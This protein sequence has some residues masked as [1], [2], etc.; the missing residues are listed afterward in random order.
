[1]SRK[2]KHFVWVEIDLAALRHNLRGLRALARKSGADMLAI[3]KADAYG[4]G[5]SEIAKALS[6]EGVKFFGVATLD[7]AEKL[8]VQLPKSKI[9]VLGSFHTGQVARYVKAGVRPTISSVEDLRNFEKGF[10]KAKYPVHVKVD[11]GMG[12]LGVWH[13]EALGLFEELSLSKRVEIEGIYTHF[14][15]ADEQDSFF[16]GLQL[17]RFE[18]VLEKVR[19]MG[20]HP[21]YAHAANSL[22]LARFKKSHL[23]LVRPGILLYGL[24]PGLGE[25]PRVKLKPVMSLK[26]RISFLKDVGAEEPLS[27]GRTF[28]TRKPT[29]IATVPVGYS[30]GY[31]V[32]LSNKGFVLAKGRRC[33]VVGRVTM[34]QTLVDVGSVPGIRRWDTVTLIGGEGKGRVSAEELA[35]WLGTI[36][37]EIVCAIHSRVPRVYKGR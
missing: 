7:E 36:P 25:K 6:R 31:R 16:T 20:F 2:N 22:G 33:P 35:G 3:V 4:H 11:T 27:Y 9:L 17:H 37:Y 5:M 30:H 34:D 10:K 29:R 14:S 24:N 8:R 28:Q 21:R 23:N 32:G 26:A 18:T 19:G 12:R 15:S 1:M 13:G